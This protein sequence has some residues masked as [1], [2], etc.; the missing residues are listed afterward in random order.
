LKRFEYDFMRDCM[1]K[2]SG[3]VN[4]MFLHACIYSR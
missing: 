2:V 1:V 3:V 4:E